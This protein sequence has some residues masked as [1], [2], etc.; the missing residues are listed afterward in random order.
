MTVVQ[1]L[2][3]PYAPFSNVKE[4]LDRVRNQNPDKILREPVSTAQLAEFLPPGN[5]PRGT[6]ILKYLGI[7]DGVGRFTDKYF[8]LRQANDNEY[9]NV[10]GSLVREA[11]SVIF[12][13][14]DLETASSD[15][16]QEAFFDYMP[17][18]QMS[19]IVGL[20]ISLCIEAKIRPPEL[21]MVHRSSITRSS[22]LQPQID[23]MV[24]EDIVEQ[25][26]SDTK[27]VNLDLMSSSVEFD[28][29]QR[30][31][32]SLWARQLSLEDTMSGISEQLALLA[33]KEGNNLPPSEYDFLA[34]FLQ[35]LP[36][37][38]KWS[39]KERD[40]WMQGMKSSIEVLDIMIDIVGE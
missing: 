23:F 37:N 22:P 39:Q 14:I 8:L 30:T 40:R 9:P 35:K 1:G 32:S 25:T 38:R 6:M 2:S 29:T 16:I 10:L 20:F 33:R 12:S 24:E 27:D 13:R 15:K 3:A 7:I 31:L 19:R 4:L 36:R 21:S 17:S 18:N 28:E 34:I 26:P 11:Y 5:A